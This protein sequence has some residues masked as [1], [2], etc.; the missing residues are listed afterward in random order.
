M[1]LVPPRLQTLWFPPLFALGSSLR[2]SPSLFPSSRSRFI[3]FC[4][5]QIGVSTLLKGRLG[6]C[7]WTF[8]SIM[9]M[10]WVLSNFLHEIILFLK[11]FELRPEAN[12]LPSGLSVRRIHYKN[13]FDFA[14]GLSVR[15]N[16]SKNSFYFAK[17][18]RF[19]QNYD[20][21]WLQRGFT[22]RSQAARC[23]EESS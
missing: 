8:Y 4:R 19:W 17:G 1:L 5:H 6:I 3:P 7:L 9:S 2:H 12:G 14:Q 10:V 22:P 21:S 16:F 15:P 23:T 11:L 18:L 13:I 20:K